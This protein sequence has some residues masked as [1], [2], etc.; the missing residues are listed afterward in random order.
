M[1]KARLPKLEN[2]DEITRQWI[3]LIVRIERCIQEGTRPQSAEG[4]AIAAEIV[5][6]SEL[7]FAGDIALMNKFW[8]RKDPASTDQGLVPIRQEVI[9][10]IEDCLTHS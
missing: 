7:T 9:Q 6:L 1:L 10:F 5:R 8:E 4:A 2:N 3:G